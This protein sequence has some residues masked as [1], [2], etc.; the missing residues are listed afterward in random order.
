MAKGAAILANVEYKISLIS[1]IY[2]V[3]VNREGGEI[4]QKNLELL[5]PIEY[6]DDE[7]AFGKKIQEI[8]WKSWFSVFWA[9]VCKAMG[10]R[11]TDSVG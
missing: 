9:R 8:T 1:G 5:G 7:I 10:E 6:T 2:E 11:L 4:M 3:L